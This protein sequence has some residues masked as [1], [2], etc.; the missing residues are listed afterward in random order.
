[1]APTQPHEEAIE[2]LEAP[3]TAFVLGRGHPV[4]GEGD[5]NVLAHEDTGHLLVESGAIG[6]DANVGTHA[7]R[8]PFPHAFQRETDELR[9]KE[10][11]S[12]KQGQPGPKEAR[13]DELPYRSVEDLRLH[14]PRGSALLVAVSAA[15]VAPCCEHEGDIADAGVR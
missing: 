2:T 7:L 8:R 14:H 1:M 13:R 5:E 4:E 12:A 11:F 15:E 10:R 9:R 3:G 6:D